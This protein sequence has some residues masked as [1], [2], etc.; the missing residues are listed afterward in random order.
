MDIRLTPTT[1]LSLYVTFSVVDEKCP[2]LVLTGPEIHPK[3]WDKVGKDLSKMIKGGDSVPEIIFSYWSLIRDIINSPEKGGDGSHLL[4]IVTEFLEASRP[5]SC[6]NEEGGCSSPCPSVVISIPEDPSPG[7]IKSITAPQKETV[8]AEDE[9]QKPP[10]SIYPSLV[11]FKNEIKPGLQDLDRWIQSSE[12]PLDSGSENELEVEAAS[13]EKG[14]YGRG[15]KAPRVFLSQPKRTP[16][17]P[18]YVLTAPDSMPLPTPLIQEL[19]NTKAALKAQI[20]GLKQVLALQHELSD[21]SV[22]IQDLQFTMGKGTTLDK[23]ANSKLNRKMAYPV[24]TWSRARQVEEAAESQP[25]TTET[26]PGLE[27][28]AEALANENR[29]NPL[30][31][32]ASWTAD[33][34]AGKGKFADEDKQKGLSTGILSQTAQAALAAWRAQAALA[35]WRA[36][37]STGATTTPLIKIIQGPQEPYAQFMGRLQEIAERILGPEEME[38]TLVK[39][40]AFENANTACKAA[41]RGKMRNIDVSGMIKVCNEVDNFGHQL[42]KSISL[43]IGAVFQGQRGHSRP[44]GKT[45]FTCGQLGHFARECPS[46]PIVENNQNCPENRGGGPPGPC[47]RCRWGKH[48]ARY[49]KS[50]TDNMGNSLTP[51]SATVVQGN[52]RGAPIGGP[53]SPILYQPAH[54]RGMTQRQ[55]PFTG[56]PQ[57]AQDWTCAPPPPR[58]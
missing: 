1:T 36:V 23:R 55:N 39:Q 3:I 29:R 32:T 49:C 50:K 33:K 12:E 47:P 51:V 54:A 8:P 40:L 45:C 43:A 19:L 16:R 11:A 27:P 25:D 10:K 44:G 52:G 21:L 18:P 34:I 35:A 2:W 37:P 22:Q 17:P 7:P 14:R 48:W 41:L 5:P 28:R 46:R 57:G 42:S 26:P 24:L 13:Y 31:Q 58:L 4:T 9:I 6:K 53:Y 56:P 20:G 30:S 15:D 38:G